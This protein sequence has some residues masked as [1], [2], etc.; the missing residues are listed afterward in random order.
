MPKRDRAPLG[1]P[2]WVDLFSSDTDRARAF[3]GE[4]FGWTSEQSGPE[5]GGY[6]NF[7]KN[8]APIAGCMHNDGSQ[9]MPDTWSVYLATDDAQRTADATLA[10]GG[11]VYAPAGSLCA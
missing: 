10:N 9:G 7:V 11:Q 4:L 5:F 2:C 3:Y 1:A 6:V 8:G